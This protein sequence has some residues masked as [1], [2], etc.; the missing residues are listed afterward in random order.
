MTNNE[1]E[2]DRAGDWT[3]VLYISSNNV[4]LNVNVKRRMRC[5][6]CVQETQ[7]LDRKNSTEDFT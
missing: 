6:K 4:R 7:H 3:I 1:G 2:V 5:V